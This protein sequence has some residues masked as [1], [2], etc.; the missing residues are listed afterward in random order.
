MFSVL[1]CCFIGFMLIV[2]SHDGSKSQ[3]NIINS[4]VFL[5]RSREY[6]PKHNVSFVDNGT[7]VAAYT[8]KIFVFVREKSVGDP[9][10]DMVTTVNI[11]A[12]VRTQLKLLAADILFFQFI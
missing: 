7:K 1:Q 10:V 2:Y 3:S 6:R 4:L 12:V 8:H 9:S 5:T 11:P